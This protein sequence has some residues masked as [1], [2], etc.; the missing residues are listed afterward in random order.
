MLIWM[1]SQKGDGQSTLGKKTESRGDVGWKRQGVSCIVACER[2]GCHR[3]SW[4]NLGPLAGP[5][6]TCQH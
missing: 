6:C 1:G 2:A 4:E 5:P 3:H